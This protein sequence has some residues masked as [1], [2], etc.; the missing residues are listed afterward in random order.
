M[1]IKIRIYFLK[2]F[3][4]I[5]NGVFEGKINEIKMEDLTEDN[6]NNLKE[7]IISNLNKLINQDNNDK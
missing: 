2:I 6:K 3:F 5:Y 1:E 4:D 7:I